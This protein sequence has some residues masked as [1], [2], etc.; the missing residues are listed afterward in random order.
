[1]IDLCS[2]CLMFSFLFGVYK[3]FMLFIGGGS[4][5]CWLCCMLRKCCWIEVN[6][7]VVLVLELVMIM[8]SVIIV[9]GFGCFLFGWYCVW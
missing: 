7:C 8:F 1:M 2:I 6:I 5:F 9:C 3:V 4:R